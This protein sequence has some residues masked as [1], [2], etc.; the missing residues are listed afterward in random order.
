MC[1]AGS[2][3]MHRNQRRFGANG[4]QQMAACATTTLKGET[5]RLWCK[6]RRWLVS[7]G[8]ARSGKE[9]DPLAHLHPAEAAADLFQQLGRFGFSG[10]EGTVTAHAMTARWIEVA[11][12]SYW[13]RL[14]NTNWPHII[15]A[16]IMRNPHIGGSRFSNEQDRT[17]AICQPDS[18]QRR[19]VSTW[20]KKDCCLENHTFGNK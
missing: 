5:E 4:F 17:S 1:C 8:G 18:V 14:S 9:V 19:S 7:A 15:L 11:A 6:N 20:T 13:Q 12:R 10:E 3:Q 16:E 2:S